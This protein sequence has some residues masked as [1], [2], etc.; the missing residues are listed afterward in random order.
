MI[1]KSKSKESGVIFILRL[2]QND[3]L[4]IFSLVIQGN[5]KQWFAKFAGFKNLCHSLYTIKGI[6]TFHAIY[7]KPQFA[8]CGFLTYKEVYNL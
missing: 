8:N 4:W 3:I 1:P 6:K 2:I 7:T 5:I